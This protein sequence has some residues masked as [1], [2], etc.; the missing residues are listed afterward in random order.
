MTGVPQ[1]CCELGIA[2][3]TPASPAPQRCG[4]VLAASSMG[5]CLIFISSSVVNVAL[6]AIGHGLNLDAHTLQWVLNAELLPLATLTLLGGAIGD[7]FGQK[8]I[9]LAGILLFG[10]ASFGCA[11]ACN[12]GQLVGGRLVQGVG[13]AMILPTGLSILGKAFSSERKAWAV[14]VWSASAAIASALGPALAGFIVDHASWRGVFHMQVPLAGAAFVFAVMWAPQAS[15]RPSV[16]IDIAAAVLSVVGLGTLEWSL[17]MLTHGAGARMFL[18]GAASVTIFIILSVVERRK[19][20]RAMLP[21]ALFASRTVIS[22]NLFSLALYGAFT[23]V[24]TLVPFVMIRGAHMNA[25][26]AGLAFIPLQILITAISPLAGLICARIGHSLPLALGALV[27]GLGCAVALKIDTTAHYWTDVF[28]AI[29]LVAV[30]MSLIV[31]P[32]TTLVLTSVDALHAATASGFNSAISRA[33]ALA[34]VALLGGVLQQSGADLID[35]FHTAM[36]VSAVACVVAALAA[37]SIAATTE[38]DQPSA[39]EVT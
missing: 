20:N 26:I 30:G 17:M 24:L 32:M 35:A 31:A 16:P 2:R 22:L 7:R 3:A 18:L 6:A 9:F 15:P 11:L 5:C 28:P 8:R 19:G 39:F 13:E 10:I 23:A 36:A 25:L 37:F 34:A 4:A 38:P 14:G 21:P 33:G 27:T 12:G 29:G 1:I